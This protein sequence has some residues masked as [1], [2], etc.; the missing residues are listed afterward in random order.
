MYDAI[1][2]SGTPRSVKAATEPRPLWPDAF[3]DWLDP[4][5]NRR[6]TAFEWGSGNGTLWLSRRVA[7]IVSVE[8]HVHWNAALRPILPDN[9]R[10]AYVSLAKLDKYA[11]VIDSF[12]RKFDLVIVDGMVRDAC[13]RRAVHHL[14]E[15][16]LLVLDNS[17][18]EAFEGQAWLKSEG[19]ASITLRGRYSWTDDILHET[20][21]FWR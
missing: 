15:N 4:R 8:H 2:S 9:S 5:L 11:A 10:L 18:T 20:R 3:I 1:D 12:T 6:M 17:D 21:V 14:A 13:I 19:W 16:G 7:S